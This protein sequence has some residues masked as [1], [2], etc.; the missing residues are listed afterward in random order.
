MPWGKQVNERRPPAV[1]PILA[2]F[3]PGLFFPEHSG[4]SAATVLSVLLSL[5]FSCSVS[6]C[7]LLPETSPMFLVRILLFVFAL[8]AILFT[9]LMHVTIT[10]KDAHPL[11]YTVSTLRVWVYQP[12]PDL[13]PFH[14]SWLIMKIRRCWI[15]LIKGLLMIS[16]HLCLK[17]SLRD[18]FLCCNIKRVYFN[19]Q[20]KTERTE[21]KGSWREDR[22]SFL[23]N[24]WWLAVHLSVCHTRLFA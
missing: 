5:S 12:F 10:W 20:D 9:P 2:D 17:A 22:K 15:G 24:H 4:S 23:L 8:L 11:P 1:S 7:Q 19:R 6:L 16:V 13:H 21:K 18:F 14:N 3:V